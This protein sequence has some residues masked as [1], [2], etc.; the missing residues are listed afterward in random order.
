MKEN[1][2]G[3]TKYVLGLSFLVVAFFVVFFWLSGGHFDGFGETT[4]IM[5]FISFVAMIVPF[6]A[7]LINHR[8]L[9]RKKGLIICVVNSL[10][11]LALAAIWPI[12]TIIRNEPC[13]PGYTICAVQFSWEILGIILFL[14][15]LYC[16]INVC[17]WVDFRKT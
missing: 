12:T 4:M 2:K 14:A 17:F 3:S 15:V 8:N 7:W 10:V 16:L 9:N 11:L 5:L 1:K 13:N 6:I